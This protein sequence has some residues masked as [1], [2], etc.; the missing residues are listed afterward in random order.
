MALRDRGRDH[1]G[2]VLCFRIR[3]A[4]VRR[5]GRSAPPDL[6]RGQ[7]AYFGMD[8]IYL[9]DFTGDIKNRRLIVG[10]ALPDS[11]VRYSP[12]KKYAAYIVGRRA[13]FNIKGHRYSELA[14]ADAQAYSEK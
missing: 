10:S 5:V 6:R 2:A 14:V 7:L 1:A 8:S 4:P 9:A 3:T 12:C 11:P 13:E